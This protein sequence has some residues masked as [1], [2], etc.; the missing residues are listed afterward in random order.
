MNAT[1]TKPDS[2]TANNQDSV[3]VT[4]WNVCGNPFGNGTRGSCL[5]LEYV[6]PNNRPIYANSTFAATCC[7]SD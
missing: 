3:P 6:G 4:I 7:V 5:P 2:I 1:L